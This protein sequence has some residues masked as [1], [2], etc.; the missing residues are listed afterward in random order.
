[1]D[2]FAFAPASD[3]QTGHATFNLNSADFVHIDDLASLN[4]LHANSSQLTTF[5]N[6]SGNPGFACNTSAQLVGHASAY[7]VGNVVNNVQDHFKNAVVCVDYTLSVME[8][9]SLAQWHPD[10]SSSSSNAT[11]HLALVVA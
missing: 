4:L 2:L 10:V 8:E 1:M 5:Q 11:I 7:I 3:F 9:L 6:V